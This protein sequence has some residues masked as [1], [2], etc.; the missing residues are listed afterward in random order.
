MNKSTLC[1]HN[2]K[3]NLLNILQRP[4]DKDMYV[5]KRQLIFSDLYRIYQE[6]RK[7]DIRAEN[8]YVILYSKYFTKRFI[9]SKEETVLFFLLINLHTL[10]LYFL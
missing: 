8:L 1:R 9:L 10:T 3:H 4:I 6:N 5:R 2:V 7:S